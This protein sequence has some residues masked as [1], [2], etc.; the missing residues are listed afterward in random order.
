MH[1]SQAPEAETHN[2]TARE[3]R[4]TL[5]CFPEGE[6]GTERETQTGNTPLTTANSGCMNLTL[7]K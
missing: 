2:L 4:V 3:E 5:H 6:R 7:E 1:I